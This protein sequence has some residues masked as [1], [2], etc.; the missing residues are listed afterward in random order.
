MPNAENRTPDLFVAG[1]ADAPE[2]R[3]FE[4]VDP[5]PI[6][7]FQSAELGE[8]EVR[9][10][11]EAQDSGP[12]KVWQSVPDGAV[13]ELRVGSQNPTGGAIARFV[14]R[15]N[16]RE[17]WSYQEM[18]PGPKTRQLRSSELGY[19]IN[20]MFAFDGDHP[21]SMAVL[22]RVLVNGAVFDTPYFHSVTGGRGDIKI[23]KILINMA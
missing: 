7:N 19:V 2:M 16:Q 13:L 22:A 21:G 9:D 1:Q 17:F 6:A 20:V 10:L 12:L 4:A 14:S 5:A 23:A 15:I 11:Q 18:N 3:E 8:P